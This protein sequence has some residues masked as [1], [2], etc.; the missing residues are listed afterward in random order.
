MAVYVYIYLTVLFR[1]FS[2]GIGTGASTALVK[3]IARAGKG[4]A[5]FVIGCERL[6]AQVEHLVSEVKYSLIR[7]VKSE[8]SYNCLW[9]SCDECREDGFSAGTV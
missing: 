4:I 3:G 9:V 7:K 1:M 8:R 2:F 5:D 6:P